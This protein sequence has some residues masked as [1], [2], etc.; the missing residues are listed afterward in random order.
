MASFDWQQNFIKDLQKCHPGM[1]I[2]LMNPRKHVGKTFVAEQM[3]AFI[4]N[5]SLIT[6]HIIIKYS[7]SSFWI[8]ATIEETLKDYKYI[9]IRFETP[10]PLVDLLTFLEDFKDKVI[11]LWGYYFRIRTLDKIT[12]VA[13]VD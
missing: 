1:V 13:Y 6:D 3:N 7:T 9:F 2:Q 4:A 10:M 11:V 12:R 8:P 5:E